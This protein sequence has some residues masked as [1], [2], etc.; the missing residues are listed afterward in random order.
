MTRVNIARIAAVAV[1]FGAVVNAVSKDRDNDGVTVVDGIEVLSGFREEA[2]YY[3]TNN[4]LAFREA[5]LEKNYID[6]YELIIDDSDSGDV[7]I[8]LITRFDSARQ[9]QEVEARYTELMSEHQL[10]LLNE[11]QPGEFRRNVF[12]VTSTSG[13]SDSR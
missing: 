5:A 7:D 8:I 2:I 4:W 6:S 11:V 10:A 1:T 3:Y 9:Y 13:E 12:G